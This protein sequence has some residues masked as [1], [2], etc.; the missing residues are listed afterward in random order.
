ML[1]NRTRFPNVPLPIWL[2]AAAVLLVAADQYAL[3]RPVRPWGEAVW[4]SLLHAAGTVV[5]GWAAYRIGR[6]R[7]AA[8]FPAGERD[9]LTV[10]RRKLEESEKLTTIGVLAAGI[11][12]EIRNPLTSLRGFVQLL[13]AGGASYTDIMLSEIDRIN[14]IVGELLLIAKPKEAKVEDVDV[15]RL[16]EQTVQFMLPQ[17]MLSG[18]RIELRT[19]GALNGV[20]IRG[21]ENKLKQVLINVIKNGM[22]AMPK[23][24]TIVV[25]A[26]RSGE[27]AAL[28]VTDSGTGMAPELLEQIGRA[29]YSTK[30]EGTGLGLMVCSSIVKEHGGTIEFDS[31]PGDGTTVQIRLP[32]DMSAEAPAPGR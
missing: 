31:A 30:E 1:H 15:N 14:G 4:E 11:A 27:E 9:E 32:A 16:L 10:S 12:H 6:G 19:D 24:G 7:K 3:Y 26:E 18:V 28:F 20:S 8:G 25:A 29:F 5:V 22:E 17:A 13:K 23:G 2:A 21:D